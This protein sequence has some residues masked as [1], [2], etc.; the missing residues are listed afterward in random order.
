[1]DLDSHLVKQKELFQSEIENL[2]KS[3]SQRIEF[4]ANKELKNIADKEETQSKIED[5]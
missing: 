1:M 5:L 3:H 2:K 4:F